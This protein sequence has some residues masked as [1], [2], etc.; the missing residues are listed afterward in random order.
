MQLIVKGTPKHTSDKENPILL[1]Q[2]YLHWLHTDVPPFTEADQFEMP[3]YDYLQA[4]L[5]V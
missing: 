1:Y 5:Q 2:K 3:Y 4:P